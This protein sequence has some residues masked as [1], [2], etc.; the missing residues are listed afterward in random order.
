MTTKAEVKYTTSEGQQHVTII[1][2]AMCPII[3]IES[4][5]I[6]DVDIPLENIQVFEES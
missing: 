2:I 5:R 3:T 4:M 6:N 1:D